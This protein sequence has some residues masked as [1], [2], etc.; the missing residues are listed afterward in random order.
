[1]YLYRFDAQRLKGFMGFFSRS[2]LSL[3]FSSQTGL[4][5]GL[6]FFTQTGTAA[7]LFRLLMD[8][9]TFRRKHHNDIPSITAGSRFNCA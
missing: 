8:F 4:L 5:T 7:A 3:L 2:L 1:M 6:A 9:L